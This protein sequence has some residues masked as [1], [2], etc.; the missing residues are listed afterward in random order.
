M[1]GLWWILMK[2]TLWR[3]LH[4]EN[5]ESELCLIIVDFP[6]DPIVLED[7][8]WGPRASPHYQRVHNT[9]WRTTGLEF[10]NLRG[11]IWGQR[12][13]FSQV[14]IST[15]V[16]PMGEWGRCSLVRIKQDA[17]GLNSPPSPAAGIKGRCQTLHRSHSLIVHTC[18]SWATK[19][20]SMVDLKTRSLW[21]SH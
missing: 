11:V 12:S 13:P 3:I 8:K 9:S 6:Y 17:R 20:N 18:C 5:I 10:Q 19:R 7:P 15:R 21:I 14:E 4:N 2:W 16:S 1:F